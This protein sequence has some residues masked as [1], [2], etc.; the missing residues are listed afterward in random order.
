MPNLSSANTGGA[1]KL[2][3]LEDFSDLEEREQD[4]YRPSPKAMDSLEVRK[5][6][7]QFMT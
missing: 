4:V 6:E 2:A 7:G 5:R 3:P 1:R